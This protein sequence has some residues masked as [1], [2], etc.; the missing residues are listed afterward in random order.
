VTQQ[1]LGLAALAED[2]PGTDELGFGVAPARLVV[3]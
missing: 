3:L 1:V 2:L